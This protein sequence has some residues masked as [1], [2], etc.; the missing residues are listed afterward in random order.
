MRRAAVAARAAVLDVALVVDARPVTRGRAVGADA[1]AADAALTGAA[2]GPAAAAVHLV[3]RAVDADPVAAR[4]ARRAAAA[5]GHAALGARADGAARA[6]VRRIAP[7]IGAPRR[8][9]RVAVR[10]ATRARVADRARRATVPARTAVVTVGERVDAG[11][12]AD[13]P[14]F[15]DALLVPAHGA[16]RAL[17]PAAFDAVVGHA[18]AVVV[19]AVAALLD[20]GVRGAGTH[21]GLAGRGDATPV[22]TG[23]TVRAGRARSS[24][25]GSIRLEG[26]AEPRCALRVRR[27]G[28]QKGGVA[29]D[30]AVHRPV[31]RAGRRIAAGGEP[32]RR[33]R[34]EPHASGPGPQ[35]VLHHDLPE[36]K[37]PA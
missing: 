33:E 25:H 18:I 21:A 6:A 24:A 15:A 3:G 19:D 34:E 26:H 8:T 5:P 31:G 2:D 12:I 10:A 27:A 23:R 17:H 36:W 37:Q 29:G 4:L 13:L 11:A 22:V 28:L 20:R 14:R 9:Q 35:D 30:A 32:E 16:V 7:Q 1:D